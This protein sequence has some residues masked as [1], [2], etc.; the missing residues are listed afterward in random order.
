RR[1]AAQ[2]PRPE[3][4][5][6]TPVLLPMLATSAAPFDSEEYL[7]EVKWDGV[8]AL[9]AVEADGWRLWGRRGTDYTARYPELAGCGRL[10]SGRVLDGELVVLHDGRADFA[11]LL[12]R[13]QRQRPDPLGAAAGARPVVSY[14]LFDLLCD[15]G[16]ALLQ[17][18]LVRRRA[19]LR[20]R[21]A[22]L[23]EPALVYSD[24][25]E[26]GGREFFA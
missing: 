22:R 1:P 14:V 25:V 8:R 16:Q 17:Q 11:A 3:E 19:R 2:A 21:L 23:N 26:G 15:R 7:F 6:M 4:D 18:A 5:G 12:S 20:E 10:P 9:A 24:A 13:H